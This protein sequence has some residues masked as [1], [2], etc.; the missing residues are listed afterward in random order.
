MSSVETDFGGIRAM[1]ATTAE[2]FGRLDIL[3]NNAGTNIRRRPEEYRMEDWHTVLATNL[4]STMI[5]SQAAPPWLKKGG[6]GRVIKFGRT[7]AFTEG[8][9]YDEDGRLLA[10]ATGTAVPT[11]FKTYQS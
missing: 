11:P 2:R 8:E 9:L 7:L 6:V 1:V 4:T 10:K 3:V 5:A